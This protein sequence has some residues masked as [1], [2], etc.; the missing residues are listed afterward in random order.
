MAHD[1]NY[2]LEKFEEHLI[3]KFKDYCD[4]NNRVP[5]EKTLLTFLAF[6]IENGLIP[7]NAIK[8]FAVWEE[9]G[10]IA[11][12]SRFSKRQTMRA[13]SDVFDIPESTVRGILKKQ[14][15]TANLQKV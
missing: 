14:P 6:L 7:Q 15:V 5:N 11:D 4:N 3:F 9:Y 2:L 13:I 8:S 12:D 1:K 10:K